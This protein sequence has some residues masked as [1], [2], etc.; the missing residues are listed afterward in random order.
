[1]DSGIN[2]NSDIGYARLVRKKRSEIKSGLKTG[3]TTIQELFQNRE[4]YQKYIANMR[5]IELVCTLPGI[6]RVKA[7]KILNSMGISFCKKIDGMGKN[8][9]RKFYK[10][11]DIKDP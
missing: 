8:Q 4:T 2:N 9:K 6:G 5:V 1:M 3:V 11:F 7:E 10:Y